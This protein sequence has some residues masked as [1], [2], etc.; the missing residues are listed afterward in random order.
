MG[1][2]EKETNREF[3]RFLKWVR[4]NNELWGIICGKSKEEMTFDGF[5]TIMLRLQEE[6]LYIP[7]YV[8]LT[9]YKDV[10][11]VKSATEVMFTGM[12]T[13][14]WRAIGTDVFKDLYH[15]LE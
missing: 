12:F 11:F 14:E 5:R 3:V 10:S 7:M 8:F 1:K 4:Q 13:K 15:A 6:S 9:V 2:N